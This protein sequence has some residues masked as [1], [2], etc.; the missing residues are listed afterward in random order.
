[1]FAGLRMPRTL[2]ALA[3]VCI[4]A[5]SP[6]AFSQAVASRL[7]TASATAACGSNFP[8]S[9][10]VPVTGSP[11]GDIRIDDACQHVY[12]ANP[13]L[14]RIEV[15]S[16]QSKTLLTPIAVGLAPQGFD[17]TPDGT[18]MY[19]ANSG[20]T[21]LSVVDV[22][23]R[24]EVRK[25]G[26]PSGFSSDKPLSIAIANNGHALF[27]TTF[28]GSGFG[29]RML[30][31]NLATDAVTPRSDFYLS[32]STTEATFLRATG[33]RSKIGIIVG[34]IST[35]PAFL[36]SAA[37]NTFVTETD[38]G[39][40]G[41]LGH[42]AGDRTGTA[43]LVGASQTYLLDA[44]FQL[45]KT[46][47]DG[48]GVAVDPLGATG[49]RATN[50]GIDILALPQLQISRSIP[51]NDTLASAHP[52][53]H[54]TRMAI[55]SDGLLLAVVTDRGFS[56]VNPNA[57]P[58]P[59]TPTEEAPATPRHLKTH[60]PA[61]AP[62]SAPTSTPTPVP[63][64]NTPAASTTAVETSPSGGRAGVIIGPNTGGGPDGGSSRSIFL[65]GAAMLPVAGIFAT[66]IGRKVRR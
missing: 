34:D 48:Y 17:I 29:G 46:I 56:L 53:T 58:T 19:V 35:G 30:D 62:T 39:P 55:S 44:S 8:S 51:V 20:E 40:Y 61:R 21:N 57:T 27:S 2:I 24:Q 36:Y 50:I 10:F 6:V 43:F 25:I 63:P 1:M 66:A 45:V 38:L 64:A 14:N 54:P 4:I 52:A 33:D 41:Y 60:T 11:L 37:S 47:P 16:L 12:A 7:S 18:T 15:Y 42:I 22:A 23:S 59:A 65:I 32:G 9:T 5:A 13:T 3:A 26:V 31:L 28:L 49:Y